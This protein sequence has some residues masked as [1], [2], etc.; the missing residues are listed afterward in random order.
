MKRRKQRP[1]W[2]YL[3]CWRWSPWL[4]DRLEPRRYR[5]W[6][7][8]DRCCPIP[9][10]RTGSRHYPCVCTC[11][12]RRGDR[13]RSCCWRCWWRIPACSS[14]RC[15]VSWW[16]SCW[17]LDSSVSLPGTA[18]LHMSGNRKQRSQPWWNSSLLLLFIRHLNTFMKKGNTESGWR[19]PLIDY[20]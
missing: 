4:K 13:W 15:R 18:L 8:R 10:R 3:S 7:S 16:R 1:R 6:S 11:R 2:L 20:W 12:C 19:D 9:W 17:R 14:A 5:N